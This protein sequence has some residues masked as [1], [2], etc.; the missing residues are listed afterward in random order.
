MRA[1]RFKV[2]PTIKVVWDV[3]AYFPCNSSGVRVGMR[4]TREGAIR[5]MERFTKR[6]RVETSA[7][8]RLAR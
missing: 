7:R 3:F 2:P 4:R 6:N 1:P 8:I 5:L